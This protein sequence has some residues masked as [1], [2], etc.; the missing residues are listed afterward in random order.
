MNQQQ[1]INFL[2]HPEQLSG[3]NAVLLNNLL[4]DFPYFQ[5]AQL[6]YLKTLHN[7]KSIHYQSQ[8]KV[9]AAYAA[10]RK[11]LYYLINGNVDKK[12]NTSIG[13]KKISVSEN[14]AVETLELQAAHD[15]EVKH[16]EQN[17]NTN[18]VAQEVIPENTIA[19][20][21]VVEERNEK[22]NEVLVES[23]SEQTKEEEQQEL[24]KEEILI[25]ASEQTNLERLNT[26]I[27][28]EAI[29]AS[30]VDELSSLKPIVV[31][32][33]QE[34][35][36]AEAKIEEPEAKNATLEA[37]GNHSFLEWLKLSQRET[38]QVKE[39]E[40]IVQESPKVDKVKS[41]L[42][43]KFITTE[44]RLS[45]KKTEFFSPINMARQSVA[46]NSSIVT[47]TLAKVYLKQGNFQKAL[48]SYEILS[49]KF[50]EKSSYFAAQILTIKQL[51]EKK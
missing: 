28:A 4:K 21:H 20:T 29:T 5:S 45:P 26:N 12:E 2:S 6:L 49:L 37:S 41:S 35:I 40:K 23:I 17:L 43:E 30:I 10:N 34:T 1:F 50:P 31:E 14:E 33:K 47:E 7:E 27:L 11:A 36:I 32:E 19:V 3:E 8:L 13:E 22:Q 25:S 38:S 18:S 39:E 46:E 48:K 24:P 15:D 42:I 51:Q 16:Q 44:P 9:A